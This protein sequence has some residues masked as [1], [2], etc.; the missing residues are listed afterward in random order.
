MR[1]VRALAAVAILGSGVSPLLAQ[2]RAPIPPGTNRRLAPDA[3]RSIAQVRG[4]L[5]R[6]HNQG[7]TTV[8][9]VTPA[10]IILGDPI[11]EPFSRWLR[12]ELSQRFPGR[13][14][15]Y[16]VH[17][18]SHWDHAEGASVFADTAQIVAHENMLREMDGRIPQMPGDMLDRNQNGVWEANEIRPARCGTPDMDH[19]DRNGDGIV[20]LAEYW[21]DIR[22]PDLVY[23]ERMTLVLGGQT[24][25][26]L[27]PGQ[28]HAVDATVMYFPAE[29]AVF[30]TEFIVDA[31]TTGFRSWPAACGLSPGFDG[32]PLAEW[33]RSIRAVEALDFDVLVPGHQQI[34]LT[35]ADVAETRVFLEDLVAAVSAGLSQGK[36]LDELKRS[37][38]FDKYKDWT[39]YEQRRALNVEAAY[40]NLRIYR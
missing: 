7:W 16:V 25:E 3:V 15:R 17:S 24:V 37:L 6:A 38:A 35:R 28:N 19:L 30:A 13:P 18:H 5:Y 21:A 4:N 2:T 39:G 27:Y 10:G 29:R 31:G 12:S 40:N 33:I 26:L 9:Y 8:F 11:S 34:Q 36:S 14:V 23:S 32:T 20:T 1:V 22:T